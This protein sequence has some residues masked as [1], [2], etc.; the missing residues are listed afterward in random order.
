MSVY[1]HVDR[2]AELVPGQVIISDK[3]YV[4][5]IFHPVL[6]CFDQSD[7]ELL[8]NELFPAGLTRHGK[9]YFLNHS[10]LVHTP[11]GIV[12]FVPHLPVIELTVELVRRLYFPERPSRFAS[13]FAWKSLNEAKL[14]QKEFGG[15][16]ILQLE[17]DASF[18][19]DMDLLFLGGSGVGAIQFAMKY[20]RGESSSSPR[21]EYLLIPPVRVIS[22]VPEYD[23]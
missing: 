17:A 22:A 15:E 6:D 3:D 13:I 9:H 7:L 2:S 12:P 16:Q 19:G 4:S 18:C 1:F 20:W 23:Q 21:L 14:F 8:V 5:C 10:L 11:E